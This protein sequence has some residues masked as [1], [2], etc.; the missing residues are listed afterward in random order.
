MRAIMTILTQEWWTIFKQWSDVGTMRRV[1][2]C[3]VLNDRLMFE[4]YWAA[5][6]RM[7]EEAGFIQG[8]FLE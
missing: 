5:F 4:Q 2:V 6:F 3:A 8:I 1:A 7:A